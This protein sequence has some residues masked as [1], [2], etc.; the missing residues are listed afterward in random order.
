MDA[1]IWEVLQARIADAS[2]KTYEDYNTGLIRFL[3]DHCNEF[4]NV[5]N[6]SIMGKL[7]IAHD[8]DR[9]T[10]TSQG[11]P[12]KKRLHINS[13]IRKALSTINPA[14]TTTHPLLLEKLSFSSWPVS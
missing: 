5:I 14:D 2:Q 8:N 11:A 1:E 9:N 7:S 6:P 3:F 10:R 4:P 13:T 12:S